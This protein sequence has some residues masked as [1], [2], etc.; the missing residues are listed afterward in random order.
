MKDTQNEYATPIFAFGDRME[1]R[2]GHIY[3]KLDKIL[4]KEYK[5][6][7]TVHFHGLSDNHAKN[8]MDF[9]S[10]LVTRERKAG[11][12]FDLY[13]YSHLPST[14]KYV[15]QLPPHISQ[16]GRDIHVLLGVSPQSW[17][18]NHISQNAHLLGDRVILDMSFTTSTPAG[19]KLIGI[20]E[21]NDDCCVAG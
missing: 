13:N 15:T 8:A 6:E 3:R 12:H 21:L 2:W 20:E 17:V 10:P 1:S 14:L 18:F 5:K 16:V 9:F 4:T 19:P 7:M 11:F